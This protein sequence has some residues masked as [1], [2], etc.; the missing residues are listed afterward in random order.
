V[1]AVVRYAA[2]SGADRIVMAVG[3]P[4]IFSRAGTLIDPRV[5]AVGA[6]L[7][8]HE[9]ASVPAF[10]TVSVADLPAE[11]S[12]SRACQ[13]AAVDAVSYRACPAADAVTITLRQ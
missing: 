9:H 6:S 8:L 12:D 4:P 13:T 11:A 10:K 5:S 7:G 1:T 3:K 2:A